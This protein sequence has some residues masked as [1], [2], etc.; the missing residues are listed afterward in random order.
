MG[1]ALHPSRNNCTS[2]PGHGYY[3]GEI[4]MPLEHPQVGFP[5]STGLLPSSA[6]SWY[7]WNT[8]GSTETVHDLSPTSH[9][10]VITLWGTPTFAETSHIEIQV[11]WGYCPRSR[12]RLGHLERVYRCW[13][14]FQGHP[15]LLGLTS[16][17]QWIVW[18]PW[19][20]MV[21]PHIRHPNW[22]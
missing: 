14:I 13:D 16:Q 12:G 2:P 17:A 5:W 11:L 21:R 4:L 19:A 9:R 6:P 22:R 1:R 18:S 15:G 7:T 10:V 20:S 3:L 8:L